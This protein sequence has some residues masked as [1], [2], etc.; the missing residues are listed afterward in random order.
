MKNPNF[1]AIKTRDEFLKLVSKK[2]EFAI[3]LNFGLFSRKKIS[4]NPKTKKFSIVNCIDNSKQY[5]SKKEL[6]DPK[7]TSI[8]IALRKKALFLINN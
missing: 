4:Y 6:F 1:T 5:L 8:G 2:R 7:I 3:A